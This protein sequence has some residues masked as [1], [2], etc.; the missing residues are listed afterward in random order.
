ME[1][2]NS[3]GRKRGTITDSVGRGGGSEGPSTLFSTKK[4]AEGGGKKRSLIALRG[5]RNLA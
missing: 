1:F 5:R 3:E 4:G 2:I